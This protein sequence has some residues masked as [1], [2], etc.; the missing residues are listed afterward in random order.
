MRALPVVEVGGDPLDSK[1]DG[2]GFERLNPI[3][4]YRSILFH[5]GH[6]HTIEVEYY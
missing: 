1:T 3:N 5:P 2:G 6:T 4:F